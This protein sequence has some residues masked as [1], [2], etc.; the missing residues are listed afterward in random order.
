MLIATQQ[1][2]QPITMGITSAETGPHT[3]TTGRTTHHYGDQT[4]PHTDT[5]QREE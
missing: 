1:E 5:A 3:D 2:E 4:G